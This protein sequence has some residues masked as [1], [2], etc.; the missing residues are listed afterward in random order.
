LDV[1]GSAENKGIVFEPESRDNIVNAI[2]LAHG[3]TNA[4]TH[5]TNRIVSGVPAGFQVDTP[6]MPASGQVVTNRNP[7][8]VQVTF[9]ESGDVTEWA[10]FDANGASQTIPAGIH[11]GQNVTLGP[12]DGISLTSN[13]PP[14]WRWRSLG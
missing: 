11:S 1:G 6:E 7:Y 13:R 9:V 8:E 10:L 2:R 4:A 12:G 14:T 3:Y 5:P